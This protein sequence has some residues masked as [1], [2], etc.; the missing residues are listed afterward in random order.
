MNFLDKESIDSLEPIW[1]KR[2]GLRNFA[3]II[4]GKDFNTET[5]RED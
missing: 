1:Y 5:F 3:C 2:M 4:D